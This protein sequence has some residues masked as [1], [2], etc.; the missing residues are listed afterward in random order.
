MQNLQTNLGRQRPHMLT[1]THQGI[2]ARAYCSKRKVGRSLAGRTGE[3]A[4]ASLGLKRLRHHAWTI[5][6][7]RQMVQPN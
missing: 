6:Y 1:L 2:Q 3:L 7:M 5:H 4:L